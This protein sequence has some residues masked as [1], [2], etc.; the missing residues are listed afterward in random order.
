M[1]SP[2]DPDLPDQSR[3]GQKA[4]A[5]FMH[6]ISEVVEFQRIYKLEYSEV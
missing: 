4:V 1:D 5:T 2:C 6:K 3:R